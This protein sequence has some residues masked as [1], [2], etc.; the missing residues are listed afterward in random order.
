MIFVRILRRLLFLLLVFF[1]SLFA[2]Q[3]SVVI[4]CYHSFIGNKPDNHYDFSVSQMSNHIKTISSLGF[5]FVSWQEILDGK[6][7]GAKNVLITVDDGHKTINDVWPLFKAYKIKPMLFIYPAIV[8]RKSNTCTTS[9]LRVLQDQGA[10]LGG[11][12]W[13]HLFIAQ[14]LFDEDIVAFKRE[15]YYGRKKTSLIARKEIDVFAYPFGVYSDVTLEHLK[16]AGYKYAFTIDKGVQPLPI[17]KGRGPLLIHRY[18]VTFY[19]WKS[20]R[21]ILE[22]GGLEIAGK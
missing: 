5:R 2:S 18:M 13:N 6:V 3:D 12:G 17:S 16:L 10:V 11:H 15:I 14:K 19:S 9:N 7:K 8:D 1:S 4:L 20:I 22:N 21:K